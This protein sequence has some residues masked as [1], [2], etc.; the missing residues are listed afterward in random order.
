MREQPREDDFRNGA[1]RQENDDRLPLPGHV[2]QMCF[3]AL[4]IALPEGEEHASRP[5]LPGPETRSGVEEAFESPACLGDPF[6]RGDVT[7]TI[8]VVGHQHGSRDQI[9]VLQLSRYSRS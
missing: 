6:R 2:D 5:C 7:G 1:I 8:S 9:E 3:R 4:D